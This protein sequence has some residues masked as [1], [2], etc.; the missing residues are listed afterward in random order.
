MNGLSKY[1]LKKIIQ[2]FSSEHTATETSK[3]LKVNRNTVNKYYRM[4]REAVVD[5]QEVRLKYNVPKAKLDEGK[6]YFSWHTNKGLIFSFKEGDP[7]YFV[8]AQ[9]DRI[10][11]G[12]EEDETILQ[13]LLTEKREEL[14]QPSPKKG[15]DLEER[16]FVY[17]KEQLAKFYGVRSQYI[18]MYLKELEF[19]FNNKDKDLAQLIWKIL[20]HHSTTWLK[21]RSRR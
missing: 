7:I 18:Y 17:A 8:V 6:N 1:Y 14:V 2:C 3:K 15:L 12:V 4:I 5:Y 19:R 10:Y 21:V 9:N 20:P 16:F 11:V 13:D